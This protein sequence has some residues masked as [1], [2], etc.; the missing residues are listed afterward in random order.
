MAAA[1]KKKRTE[2]KCLGHLE[3]DDLGKIS[4]FADAQSHITYHD[5][6]SRSTTYVSF[7]NSGMKSRRNK[8]E[9][10]NRGALKRSKDGS[11]I[12]N[13]S[14]LNSGYQ[15]GKKARTSALTAATVN[16]RDVSPINSKKTFE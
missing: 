9:R 1:L 12:S 14:S 8:Y 5:T 10:S 6:P 4:S 16:G 7:G 2:K 11:F 3:G 13:M 15:S